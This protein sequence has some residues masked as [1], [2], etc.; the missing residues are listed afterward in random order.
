L[1]LNR[2]PNSWFGR[3]AEVKPPI[4]GGEIRLNLKKTC[5][6]EVIVAV[7]TTSKCRGTRKY[8]RSGSIRRKGSACL[9]SPSTTSKGQEPGS[10]MLRADL[11]G[12]VFGKIQGG[13]TSADITPLD[14]DLAKFAS[15]ACSS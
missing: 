11:Q 5:A 15:E 4:P 7:D 1:R 14:P 10:E 2:S 13:G 6:G 3:H 12:S 8:R 9:G